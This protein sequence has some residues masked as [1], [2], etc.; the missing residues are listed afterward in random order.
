MTP[1]NVGTCMGPNILFE[2][3]N[4][5]SSLFSNFESVIKV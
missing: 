1:E 5:P 2:K 3:G 4:D